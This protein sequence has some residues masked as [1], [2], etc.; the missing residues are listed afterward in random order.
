MAD[1][2]PLDHQFPLRREVR[3]ADLR[4]AR[5]SVPALAAAVRAARQEAGEGA[6]VVVWLSELHLH[7]RRAY[8][9]SFARHVDCSANLRLALA[10]IVALEPAPD[11]VIF[12]GDLAE[13]GCHCDAPADEY[14]E[15]K[16]L[17]DAYL[18]AHLAT[19][20]LLGNHDH[21]DYPLSAAWHA[22]MAQTK[23]PEWPE[24]VE[25]EDFYY[26]ARRGGWRFI[27][28]DS[29]QE[30]PLSPRQRAWLSG[31]LA[32]DVVTPTAVLVHRPFVPVGNWVDRYRLAD[33]ASFAAIDGAEAV[34]VV[35]SGHT[36]KAKAW[37]YR[38]K[39]HAV[40]PGCACGMP[41]PCGWGVVVLGAARVHA[42]FVKDLA[43][44]TY[45]SVGERL[46]DSGGGFRKLIPEAFEASGQA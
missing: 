2:V 42:V 8:R 29:R 18:P 17:F 32:A 5:E 10:E 26:E 27:A 4:R 19:L 43:A 11:L 16:R 35:L 7:A 12:G 22:T 46:Q 9:P 15:M 31:R 28:L 44:E 23:R 14:L 39:T 34:K 13:G 24:P 20:P 38:G 33:Q 30:Q 36:H 40:F 45:D 3:E 25:R 21:A 1:V 37:T 6:M 41:D